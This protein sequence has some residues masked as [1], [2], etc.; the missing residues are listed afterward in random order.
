MLFRTAGVR[1]RPESACRTETPLG[2]R[3]S[4]RVTGALP[5]PPWAARR[6]QRERWAALPAGGL[7]TETVVQCL[8]F[9]LKLTTKPKPTPTPRQA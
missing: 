7:P 9:F 8:S 1:A 2:S 3:G 4:G 5:A 6:R